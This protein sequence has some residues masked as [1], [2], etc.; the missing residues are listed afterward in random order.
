[1]SA[2]GTIQ[3]SVSQP[4]KINI[5]NKQRLQ[6]LQL[7]SLL[8]E[9]DK[10]KLESSF[11]YFFTQSWS[12]LNP[13]TT[14]VNNFHIKLF[15]DELQNM[16]ERLFSNQPKLYDLCI[17]TP[18]KSLKSAICSVA[19]PA[20]CHIRKPS[21]KFITCSYSPGLAGR[22][23]GKSLDLIQSEWFQSK[24]KSKFKLLTNARE[25]YRNDKNG[26]RRITSPH[27]SFVGYQSDI[28][29]VDDGNAADDRFSKADRDTVN[30][31]FDETLWS[32]LDN[33]NIGIRI[34][35]Q[36]RIDNDDL[37]SHI[38]QN[39][40]DKYAYISLPADLSR[41]HQPVP[42]TL[43]S[44]YIGGL[45]SPTLLSR[46]ILLE[47]EQVQRT[48]YEGQY[49]QS[50]IIQG[51]RFFKEEWFKWFTDNQ[52]PH[53]DHLILSIDTALTGQDC[54]VSIQTWGY[55]A[56]NAYCLADY[57]EL[58]T[59]KQTESMIIRI[60]SEYPGIK[61]VIENTS[62]AFFLI[63]ALSKQF[64]IYSFNPSKWGGKEIRAGIVAPLVMQGN[65]HFRDNQY[66]RTFYL[67]EIL[68]FP[69]SKFKD[70]VDAMAQALIY[71]TQLIPQTAK[72]LHL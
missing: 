24:W 27:S 48:A 49:L 6:K 39:Y 57:T 13:T 62:N 19:F 71:F 68:T 14:L 63:E 5:S 51:G 66:F 35:I 65:V 54:P 37:T 28:I 43:K 38:Q 18:P 61:L 44:F 58:L 20:W 69:N 10:R 9:K 21:I 36:Q 32:R 55:K 22:D 40:S 45:L 52:L 60:A 53:L 17:N 29:I 30:R 7:L 8:L 41:G 64:S 47:A 1:M 56:P 42:L 33:Q 11:Y 25:Y 50:P 72:L 15:C 12:I 4:S 70:R 34:V 59:P 31:W 46:K 23:C 67:D 3:N 16:A 2:I 26:E